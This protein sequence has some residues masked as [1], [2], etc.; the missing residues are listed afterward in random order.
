[1]KTIAMGNVRAWVTSP[2]LLKNKLIRPRVLLFSEKDNVDLK[3][4]CRPDDYGRYFLHT[5]IK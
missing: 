5:K 3:R 1:M 2:F 4:Q